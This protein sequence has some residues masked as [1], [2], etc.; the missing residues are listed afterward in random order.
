MD[1]DVPSELSQRMVALRRALH[2]EPELSGEEA[3]SADRIAGALRAMGLSP[4]TGVGGHG[5]VLDLPAVG[6]SRGPA[7]ALRADMDALPITEETGLAFASRR[8][9]VMHACGHDGHAS[10]LVGAA[11]LLA[12]Q[13][14]LSP[15][16]LLWQPAEET[17]EG[18][19]AMIEDGVLEGAGMIFGGHLDRHYPPG[20]IAI[21]EGAVNASTDTFHIRIEGEGGHGG[22]PHEALDA[23][24]VGSLLVTA[25]Q[26]IVSREINPA[27]PS[28]VSVGRFVAG[29]APNVIAGSA[30]LS[31]TI[32][33]HEAAVRE[34]LCRSIERIGRAVGEL[35]A[36]RVEV[37]IARGTPAV[38]NTPEMAEL[39]RGAARAVVGARGVVEL[40]T[41][42][43]GGE[44]FAHFLQH[45]PGCY[46]RIGG[47][48]PGR[49]S[50]PAH[51]SRFDFDER[52]LSIGAAFMAEL[53]RR[54]G[55]RLREEAAS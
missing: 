42:N 46:V 3:R 52:A 7:V 24:V 31:G 6:G 19:L 23:V 27:H 37:T 35:H 9:G 36:A 29:S 41:P 51:S 40:A 49:E 22:R 53:A 5:V 16:R 34:H 17:V 54:A 14:G 55:Q 43:M 12:R 45:V 25:L 10:L 47:Q 32:R 30:E 2:A 13:P 18:A 20:E 4:R 21:S 15:L 50:Y 44:D 8:S 39:A 26:T 38:V 33:S 28:V 11:G 48:V 1:G